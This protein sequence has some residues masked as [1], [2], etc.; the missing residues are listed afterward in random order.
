MLMDREAIKEY[1]KWDIVT[2]G[3]AGDNLT[4][5]LNITKYE[6][7]AAKQDTSQGP[8]SK[9][10][11]GNSNFKKYSSIENAKNFPSYYQEGEEVVVT[12]KIH[13]TNFRAGYVPYEANTFWKKIIKFFRRVPEYEFVYGSHNVQMQDRIGG[14][15][16]WNEK[17]GQTKSNVYRDAVDKYDLKEKLID[18]EVIYGEIYGDGIQKDYTYGCKQGEHRLV[19][20]DIKMHDEWQS[21]DYIECEAPHIGVSFAPVLYRGPFN[22]DAIKALTVGD[23]VLA[24]SQKVREGV[25]VKNATGNRKILKYIS[26]KYLYGDQTDFH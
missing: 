20:F 1:L 2:Q 26:D 17:H 12:E 4:K 22:K 5:V 18:G 23:S 7:P 24:P 3:Q 8:Q 14:G 16:T 15:K 19:L 9:P 10:K 21:Q 13:G 11:P 6:P 25:V